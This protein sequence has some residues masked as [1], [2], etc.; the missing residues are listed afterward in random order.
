MPAPAPPPV[1]SPFEP[2]GR[3]VRTVAAIVATAGALASVP[4]PAL[5]AAKPLQEPATP[6][7]M[8]DTYVVSAN[9]VVF[10][11][12]G[13]F[14]KGLTAADVEVVEDGVPQ[15]ISFFR[16]ATDRAE[17]RIPL[18]VVLALDTSG[19]MKRNLRFL[20]EAATTFVNKLE[21]VDTVMVV[22]FNSSI[23]G[24]AEFTDDVDHLD[25][26]IEGLEAWGGTSLY[27]AVHYA[28]TRVMN[29][30]G[31]KAVV[32]FSD[33]ADHDSVLSD[34]DVVAF[35]QGVE[36]TVYSVAIEGESGSKEFL[37][38]VARESGGAYFSPGEVREL[39]AVFSGIANELHNHYHLGYAPKL[40]P[41]GRWRAIEVRI[42]NRKGLEVRT[43]KGYVARK[44]RRAS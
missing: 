16:E 13:R 14:A 4:S 38:R 36:A 10:D 37:K 21:D 15:E 19:S 9:V 30:G 18:S 35:A 12:A 44:P 41:D 11:S 40:P 27:D 39:S 24:S 25:R 33:G 32:V 23:K 31:R 22:Q 8:V 28:L 2:A 42:M 5:R 26:F 3:L 7:I 43:R 20:K 1:R 6:V 17:N 29:R 34:D